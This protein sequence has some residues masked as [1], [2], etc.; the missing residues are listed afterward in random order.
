MK[1]SEAQLKQI[2]EAVKAAERTT[3]GEIVPVV[4]AQAREYPE[5][6][7][8]LALA[9]G[10]ASGLAS[11]AAHELWGAGWSLTV[12]RF[13][14]EVLLGSAL[15][16]LAGLSATLRR[17]AVGREDLAEAVSIRAAAEFTRHGVMNTGDRCG[18]LLFVSLF[19]HRAELVADRGI[20]SA[21][22]SG[23]W[24][25]ELDRMMVEVHAQGLAAALCS[26]ITRI[27]AL[28]SERFPREAGT[29]NELADTLRR[30]E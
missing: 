1:L 20:H 19:E 4:I 10:V 8:L 16:L 12:G 14:L 13:A 2:E 25:A 18:V 5:A 30:G 27:G 15:G 26:G 17:L 28:L 11:F 6:W 24:Q 21:V 3:R 7:L 23:Y 22:P 9:G 29:T